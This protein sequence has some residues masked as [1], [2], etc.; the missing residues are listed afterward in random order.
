MSVLLTFRKLGMDCR[1]RVDDPEMEPLAL[2]VQT[3]ARTEMRA[4]S[5]EE[6]AELVWVSAGKGQW[7]IFLH[8]EPWE[9]V[10]HGE[11]NLYFQTDHILDG[12]ARLH[13]PAGLFLHAGAA[14]P[15]GRNAVVFCGSSGAGKTS[16][17]T[18]CIL[19]GW[20]WL[21]DELVLIEPGEAWHIRG[22]RRNFNLKERSFG[23]F[24]ETA[25]GVW[26]TV[27]GDRRGRIRFF[28][29]DQ[30]GGG[31]WRDSASVGCLVFPEYA[32]DADEPAVE[33]MGSREALG[34][35]GPE[36]VSS[37]GAAAMA[38]MLSGLGRIPSYRL[39]YRDPRRAVSVLE[40]ITGASS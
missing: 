5:P 8:G 17:V 10:F 16:L 14:A 22:S 7:R 37:G 11:A 28:D 33:R 29:P 3:A 4:C 20:S 40:E 27:T 6:T 34:R 36:I 15:E 35:L 12:L 39:R 32:A 23:N 19:S 9:G 38:G 26:E 25:P 24:P 21:T 2:R 30:L 18:S 13:W 31:P 1:L